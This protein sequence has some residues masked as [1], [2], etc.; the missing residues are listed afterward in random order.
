MAR[1]GEKRIRSWPLL[2]RSEHVERIVSEPVMAHTFDIRFVR[3]GGLAGL[4]EAPANSFRWKGAGRLS[5]DAQGISIAVKRGLLSLFPGSRRVAAAELTEVMREGDALRVEFTTGN[6]A[7][8]VIPFWVRDA[9]TAQEIVRLL[10]TNRTV[11][12]EHDAA[13]VARISFRVDWRALALLSLA[14][15]GIVGALWVSQS[16]G[17]MATAPAALN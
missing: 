13:G 3:S 4:F 7:R 15:M 10:P 17:E 9:N 6:T 11:E 12:L 5:I 8:A 2:F 14:V 1:R 16:E